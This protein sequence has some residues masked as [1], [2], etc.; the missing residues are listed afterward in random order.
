MVHAHSRNIEN[1]NKLDVPSFRLTAGHDQRQWAV[2][3]RNDFAESS[4]NIEESRTA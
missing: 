1:R 2:R 3:L 4:G